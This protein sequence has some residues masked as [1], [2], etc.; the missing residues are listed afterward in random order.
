[1]IIP[2]GP[3]D[4]DWAKKVC[5]IGQGRACCRYLTMGNK[6]WSCAK[7]APFKAHLDNRVA[8]GDMRAHGD[9]CDGRSS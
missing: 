7:H 4:D 3:P 6:G 2:N 8:R 1:M 9:N 5:K